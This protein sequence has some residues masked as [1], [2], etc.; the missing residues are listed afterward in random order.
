MRRC[1]EPASF[2]PRDQIWSHD[3][4]YLRNRLAQFFAYQTAALL[5]ADAHVHRCPR[6]TEDNANARKCEATL[7]S[8]AFKLKFVW[9][10]R[11]INFRSPCRCYVQKCANLRAALHK[12]CGFLCAS[13]HPPPYGI[14]TASRHT[15]KCDV[16]PLFRLELALS[17]RLNNNNELNTLYVNDLRLSTRVSKR[18]AVSSESGCP[19][20][21]FKVFSSSPSSSS[22][23]F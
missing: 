7:G 5:E 9:Q 4:N 14:L 12:N 16:Q 8:C 18:L 15:I 1:N 6:W 11:A 10:T 21:F 22:R 13:R 19:A 23:G 3:G 20:Q 17:L 2:E